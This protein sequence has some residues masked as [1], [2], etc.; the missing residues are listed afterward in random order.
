MASI[1]E[2]PALIRELSAARERVLVA[3]DGRCAAGKTTLAA[4]LQKELPCSVFHMDDFFLR[5]EQRTEE[6]YREAGGNVDYER[7]L[8]EVLQP[9]RAGEP[10]AYRPFDCHLQRLREP[11]FVAPAPVAVIEGTYSCHPAL[12]ENY[13]LC[14][15]LSVSPEEQRRRLLLRDPAHADS[16]FEKWIP[17]EERYFSHLRIAA[18]CLPVQAP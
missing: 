9:L 8:A 16:F 12:R 17:L 14:L 11:V 7:F 5:P 15:F 1:A 3:I 18:Q 6:R 2:I 13:D 4:Q 10:V